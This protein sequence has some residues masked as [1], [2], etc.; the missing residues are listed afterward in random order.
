MADFHKIKYVLI[1]FIIMIIGFSAYLFASGNYRKLVGFAKSHV[2]RITDMFAGDT[3][4]A[5]P[6]SHYLGYVN[7]TVNVDLT[8][9]PG[10]LR[11]E[12]Y[13]PRTGQAVASGRIE[14]GSVK[15]FSPPASGDF[16]LWVRTASR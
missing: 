3:L 7:Q 15:S 16:V 12:W 8:A 10:S 6:G 9:A 11:Y 13:N 4:L 5:N 14:G 2:T 1:A